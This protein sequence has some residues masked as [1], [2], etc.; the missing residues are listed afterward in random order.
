[1]VFLRRGMKAL[2]ELDGYRCDSEGPRANG[3]LRKLSPHQFSFIER[4]LDLVTHEQGRIL[5]KTGQP[6]TYVYFVCGG[7]Y[8]LVHSM[9]E[10]R[11]VQLA[12]TGRDGAVGVEAIMDCPAALN[13]VVVSVGPASRSYR[14]RA[15]TLN[16]IAAAHPSMQRLLSSYAATV[17]S[18]IIQ[19]SACNALHT[20][21]QRLAKLLLLIADRMGSDEFLLT[22]E[23]AAAMLGVRRATVSLAASVL[24]R[25]GA[26]AYQHGSLSIR[27]RAALVEHCCECYDSIRRNVD[28]V[29]S[30]ED[31]APS[32]R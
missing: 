25:E 16:S 21:E 9:A 6:V 17:M 23:S 7:L 15:E 28:E 1:M 24:Q 8:S 26:I 18:E 11:F 27:G 2:K 29:L 14:M 31:A 13:D 12:M 10:G 20:V 4:H 30:A 3:L 19:T 22:Q 5:Q 32:S